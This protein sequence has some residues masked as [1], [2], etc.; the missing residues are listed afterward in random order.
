[1]SLA[2]PDLLA[3]LDADPA[4]VA[5]VLPGLASRL[6]RFD[7]PDESPAHGLALL[8]VA[9][10]TDARLGPAGA[11]VPGLLIRSG[12]AGLLRSNPAARQVLAA[13]VARPQASATEC[14]Q[15]ISTAR[16]LGLYEFA[17]E[18]L[19]PAARKRVLAA[20][21]R[22]AG[23]A[24]LA[25][26][27]TL[28]Q[29][30]AKDL[31]DT[32]IRQ[33]ARDTFAAWEPDPQAPTEVAEA[34]SLGRTL[35]VREAA[36]AALKVARDGRF[37]GFVRGQALCLLGRIGRPEQAAGIEALLGDTSPVG[38]ASVKALTVRAEVRD[39]ALAALAELSGR[40]PGTLGF[41][42]LKA[43]GPVAYELPPNCYGFTGDDEREAALRAWRDTKA[44]AGR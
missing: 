20:C 18:S 2:Q 9:A 15:A 4:T 41:P 26:A 30:A 37:N 5:E 34:L 25:D 38:S 43:L 1:M 19:Y 14:K 3:R 21:D 39:V 31:V 40:D 32:R 17:A 16:N 23:P 12:P 11:S 36:P 10:E 27:L 42:Y 24:E 8:F 22:P 6:S 13:A 35:N 29:M 7:F 44:S 28:S 33:A